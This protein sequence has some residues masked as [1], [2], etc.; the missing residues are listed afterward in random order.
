[1]APSLRHVQFL[2]AVTPL[3]FDNDHFFYLRGKKKEKLFFHPQEKKMGG[4]KMT[5]NYKKQN[6]A[7]REK[8]KP[9]K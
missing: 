3:C 5:F 1:M 4:L 6:K 7:K 2:P 9:E 8:D